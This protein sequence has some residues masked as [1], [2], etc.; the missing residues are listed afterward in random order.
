LLPDLH[1]LPIVDPELR[2][3]AGAGRGHPGVRFLQAGQVGVGVGGLNLRLDR[4]VLSKTSAGLTD[5]GLG[6]PAG[7]LGGLLVGPGLQ[8]GRLSGLVGEDGV[9]QRLL[10]TGPRRAELTLA[11][12]V[13]PGLGDRG[14]RL[15][16]RGP[17][18][19]HLGVRAADA[20]RTARKGGLGALQPAPGRR[21]DHGDLRVCRLRL[22]LRALHL[23]LGLLLPRLVVGVVDLYQKLPCLTVWFSVMATCR[24]CPLTRVATGTTSALT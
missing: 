6:H 11:G 15:G 13:Q 22:C 14:F 1:K 10:R 7:V 16:H 5:A 3:D 21:L 8:K 18:R 2:R 23:R 17:G 4:R 24:T 19:R 20:D 9:V 12:Q